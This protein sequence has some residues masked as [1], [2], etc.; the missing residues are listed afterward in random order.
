[1]SKR[2]NSKVGK[3]Y[4]FVHRRD[5]YVKTNLFGRDFVS[6]HNFVSLSKDGVLRIN[7]S[8]EDGYAWD[9]CTPKFELLD[10]VFGTPDGRLDYLTEKPITYY[11]SMVHDVLY[12]HNEEIRISRQTA[13]YLFYKILSEAGFF[14]APIYYLAVRLLGAIFGKWSS[15]ERTIDIRIIECSWIIR[16]YE[17]ARSMND[18]KLEDEPLVKKAKEYLDSK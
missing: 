14:W 8:R 15:K 10:L 11:A 16:A 4:K 13:D 17:Y 12:Q 7:G 2:S 1:M 5:E 18:D 9:G 3:V 6:K